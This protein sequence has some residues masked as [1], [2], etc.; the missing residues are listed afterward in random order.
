VLAGPS[1]GQ[2]EEV[3]V[4]PR[5]GFETAIPVETTEAYVGVRAKDTL[6][7]V[8]GTSRAVKPSEANPAQAFAASPSASG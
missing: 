7:K 2:L 1:P 8:L 3:A 6:G 5:K 4:A